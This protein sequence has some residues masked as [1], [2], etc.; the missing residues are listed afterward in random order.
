MVN[1]QLDELQ[2]AILL[3]SLTTKGSLNSA[4][5]RELIAVVLQ[6]QSLGVVI[7]E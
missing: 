1:L 7:N 2:A 4:E 5:T 3:R 6:L